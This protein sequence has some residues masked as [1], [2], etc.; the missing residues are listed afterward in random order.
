MIESQKDKSSKKYSFA[1]NNSILELHWRKNIQVATKTYQNKLEGV[2]ERKKDLIS[3]RCMLSKYIDK[4]IVDETNIPTDSITNIVLIGSN[5][6]LGTY[7]TTLSK[8]INLMNSTQK[9]NMINITRNELD[10]SKNEN[11]M[12]NALVDFFK[13]KVDMFE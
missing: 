12:E 2:V 8:Q 4:H 9:V 7:L 10:L 11:I 1:K 6:M 5:G 3:C 13:N